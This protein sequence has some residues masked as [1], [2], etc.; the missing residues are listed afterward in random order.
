[1]V[2]TPTTTPQIHRT[3][4]R[5]TAIFAAAAIAALALA[6][7]DEKDCG[8][9]REPGVSSGWSSA[10]LHV[11]PEGARPRP[12]PKP[13]KNKSKKP[14]PPRKDS[15]SG[16]E[17]KDKTMFGAKGQRITSKTLYEA[18]IRGYHYRIDVENPAPGKRPGSLHV[19]LGGR[20]STHYEYNPK[21]KAFTTR[22]GER[23]PRRVQQHLDSDPEAQRKIRYG[24]QLLGER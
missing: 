11:P 5:V 3:L 12:K 1:M 7:C 23:L 4:A 10:A 18:D 8:A 20:G 9:A 15:K 24:L 2:M 21:T 22:N 13:S 6:G 19:Q 17:D 14:C 16:K